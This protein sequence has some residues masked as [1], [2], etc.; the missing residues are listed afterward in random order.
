MVSLLTQ[1]RMPFAIFLHHQASKLVS[2]CQAH[3]WAL[4]WRASSVGCSSLEDDSTPWRVCPPWGWVG[5]ASVGLVGPSPHDRTLHQ[6]PCVH[7]RCGLHRREYFK[8]ESGP[9][10]HH[11]RSPSGHCLRLQ[12][13]PR[14]PQHIHLCEGHPPP[15]G[16]AQICW[17]IPSCH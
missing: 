9:G 10:P 4:S 7:Q 5:A 13:H 16:I 3:C 8:L 17:W 1:P 6:S 14:R 11:H 12:H 15:C 2:K